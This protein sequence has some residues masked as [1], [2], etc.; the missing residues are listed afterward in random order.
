VSC[1]LRLTVGPIGLLVLLLATGLARLS[2]QETGA[3][4][5]Q[6]ISTWDGRPLPGVTI[7]VRG[8]T[9]AGQ[10][11]GTGRYELKA[12]PPGDQV[13][14]LT[15]GGYASAT[16]TDVRVL[17]GLTTTVNGNLRPEFFELDEFE[18]TAEEFNEQTTQLME[19]RSEASGLL[20]AIGADQF[21]RIG[22]SDAA[23]IVGKVPGITVADGKN[24][25][26]RGL[27]ER[28]VGI[29]LNG[30]EVPS[31]DPYR[32][33]VQLDLFPA[34]LISQIAVSKSFTPE[35]PGNAS[36]GAINVVTK[37]FPEKR[38]FTAGLGVE[39][40]LQTTFKDSFLGYQGGNT[41][42][43]ALDDGARELPSEL[44]APLPGFFTITVRPNQPGFAEQQAAAA[45]LQQLTTLLGPTEFAPT[46][47]TA[48]L[49]H[50]LSFSLGD[51]VE[52]FGRRLGVF[53]GYQYK[54]SYQLNEGV[55]ER[56]VADGANPGVLVPRRGFTDTRGIQEINW[57]AIANV[58][59]EFSEG[60]EVGFNFLFNQNAEDLARQQVGF[61]NDQSNYAPYVLN[62]LIWT[63]RNLTT[64][65]LKGSHVFAEAGDLGVDW[66]G[67]YSTT[68]QDEPDARFFNYAQSGNEFLAEGNFLLTPTQPTRYFRELAE[69][70]VNLKLD[71]K[72]PFELGNGLEGV[73]KGGVFN[74][75]SQ[76]DFEDRE[77]YYQPANAPGG[78]GPAA[79]WPFTGDPNAFF[80]EEAFAPTVT[81]NRTTGRVTYSWNRVIQ[82]RESVYDAEQKIRAGY[83]LFELP[84]HER[85]K[86]L[87]GF[88]Y[89][90]TDLNVFSVGALAN[91]VTGLR[92]NNSA[93]KQ[94][95]WLPAAGFTYA[96]RT[97][98]NFRFNF[99]QTV[100][101][102]SFRELA[103][104]RQYDPVIDELLEGN[105]LL[106]MSSVN[107]YDV[108][109]EWFPEAG[110]VVSVSLFRKDL[111]NAIE[112]RFITV[113]GE[114]ISFI[115]RP[116][117]E[118]Q[119]FE[120]ELR[121]GLGFWTD[122]L[123]EFSLGFNA[124]YLQSSVELTPEELANRLQFLGDATPTR[125]LYDQSPYIFNLDATWDHKSWGTTA[126]VVFSLSGPRITIAG[127]ATPDIYEQ[128]VPQLDFI[129]GQKLSEH[130]KL[131]LSVRNV[132]DP[133]IER[134]YGNDEGAPLYSAYTKGISVGLSLSYDF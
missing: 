11:D 48:P 22:A 59:Y 102:P 38:T 47:E 93:I 31:S 78:F 81:T 89:E 118:V 43:L 2:A 55:S 6:V 116:K 49:N 100:A 1:F 21:S 15:K 79:R 103:A 126:T 104:Y 66:L 98:M 37:S 44:R 110:A 26:V 113:D 17:P 40:N 71:L 18:V 120:V 7:V 68:S 121:R 9:L 80:P 125:P 130:F 99:G 8:T 72:K 86:L 27:N 13:L 82:G 107:N 87:S 69:N 134:T 16:V 88:R 29:T 106:R 67:A 14:R 76:R 28:Y 129:L 105:P 42:W 30:A 45:Q 75:E 32:K 132:L 112:R 51:T 124:A 115:N 94:G 19:E 83:F 20:D 101:R 62:R 123:A 12:V 46:R 84:L 77:I 58:A 133:E 109:W 57:A 122:E 39:Y 34:G 108:R 50:N 4:A 65:Q 95:D 111:Q 35:L 23:D 96:L 90:T 25:V 56:W 33:S 97:N 119:G 52:A 70:N 64:Y 24:P 41:D 114:I 73:L 85:F 3:V 127:L 61:N 5:G 54:H 36:G 74:S 117:S 92:T 131:R 10:S 53:G 63:E 128:P 60:Q 91:S